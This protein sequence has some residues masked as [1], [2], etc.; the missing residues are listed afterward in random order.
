MAV[1]GEVDV[2]S[3]PRGV[4]IPRA[5]VLVPGARVVSGPVRLVAPR[6]LGPPA[7]TGLEVTGDLGRRRIEGIAAREGQVVNKGMELPSQAEVDEHK[8]PAAVEAGASFDGMSVP[9][10]YRPMNGPFTVLCKGQT[11]CV[12]NGCLDCA[13]PDPDT[14]DVVHKLMSF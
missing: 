6:H 4:V 9:V 14:E 12:K 7:Q 3:V 1:R 13:C 11:F 10:R 5:R 2:V 8:V